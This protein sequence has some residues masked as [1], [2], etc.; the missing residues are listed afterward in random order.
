MELK[1]L[2]IELLKYYIKYC[3]KYITNYLEIIFYK[4]IQIFFN[5]YE[6]EKSNLNS[7][8]IIIIENDNYVNKNFYHNIIILN[9]IKEIINYCNINLNTK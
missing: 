3:G 6:K 2:N 9:I 8:N 5:N 4:L 7:N 1:E